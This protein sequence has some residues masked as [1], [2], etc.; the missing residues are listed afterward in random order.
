MTLNIPWSGLGEFGFAGIG[1]D[2]RDPFL[3]RRLGVHPA[4]MIAGM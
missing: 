3:V 1:H 2:T 4:A